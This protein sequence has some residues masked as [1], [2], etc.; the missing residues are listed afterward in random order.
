MIL[1]QQLLP[2]SVFI[3]IYIYHTVKA[4]VEERAFPRVQHH[5][6]GYSLLAS[7]PSYNF[8]ECN[9]S[10]KSIQIK[11][12]EDCMATSYEEHIVYT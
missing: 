8:G 4:Q 6:L 12:I 10:L 7:N 11:G 5:I 9:Y 1:S 2:L 3:V